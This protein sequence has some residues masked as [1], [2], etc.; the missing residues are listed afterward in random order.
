[1]FLHSLGCVQMSNSTASKQ[2]RG[3][4]IIQ[5]VHL[6]RQLS[7]QHKHAKRHGPL[8]SSFHFLSNLK[9]YEG[10]N[11]TVGFLFSKIIAVKGC[12]CKNFV[13]LYISTLRPGLSII[14]LAPH[15]EPKALKCFRNSSNLF[16]QSSCKITLPEWNTKM[17]KDQSI[18]E[19]QESEAF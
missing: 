3:W 19:W 4:N 16:T 9:Q 15:N 2:V 7:R 5:E 1:M 10:L 13:K 17:T 8:R 12:R 6:I 18:L 11:R 14:L